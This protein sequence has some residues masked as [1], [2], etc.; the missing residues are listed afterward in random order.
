M[1]RYPGHKSRGVRSLQKY[2]V[3]GGPVIYRVKSVSDTGDYK[4]NIVNLEC[5]SCSCL[6]WQDRDLPCGHGSAAMI[7]SGLTSEESQL[8]HGAAHFYRVM[9]LD[10]MTTVN[11]IPLPS[12]S[13]LQSKKA[14]EKADLAQIIWSSDEEEPC[15]APAI[16]VSHGNST[17]KRKKGGSGATRGRTMRTRSAV[18]G[19]VGKK[20]ARQGCALCRFAGR[21][22]DEMFKHKSTT[23]PH[24]ASAA[25][26]LSD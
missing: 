4:T 1:V 3:E 21:I 11:F 20:K 25:I 10:D 17:H 15:S 12:A 9:N 14:A 5:R 22:G 6:L 8:K 13:E 23:C 19:A 16:K 26:L 24:K 2:S 7:K 18:T